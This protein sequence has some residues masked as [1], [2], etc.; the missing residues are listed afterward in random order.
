[1][2]VHS[3][4]NKKTGKLI[5]ILGYEFRSRCICIYP[6][7]YL[8][9]HISIHTCDWLLI[10]HINLG[11]CPIQ[12]PR[13]QGLM[14]LG[15]GLTLC[16]NETIAHSNFQALVSLMSSSDEAMNRGKK[17]ATSAEAS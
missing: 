12:Q 5:W 2:I 7:K 13:D 1:M 4:A 9:H 16:R 14:N 8:Y 10:L 6:S 15:L 3:F 11:S 17:T